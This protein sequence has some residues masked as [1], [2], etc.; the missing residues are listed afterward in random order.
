MKV[1]DYVA[2]KVGSKYLSKIYGVYY[3][4]SQIPFRSLPEKF[5]L[6]ANHGSGWNL[7]VRHKSRMSEG[8]IRARCGAWLGQVYSRYPEWWY[9][10]I[11]PA[12]LVEEFLED[13]AG[14]VPADYKFFVFRGEVGLIQVD[15]ARFTDHRRNLYGPDWTPLEASLLY[16]RGAEIPRPAVF[17]EMTRVAEK[18]G[19]DFDF[20][21][22]DLYALGHRVVF[23]EMTYL[24]ESGS[25]EFSSRELDE[26]M[27]RCLERAFARR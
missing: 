5:V 17:D 27:T 3:Q 7:L 15:T 2:S 18:L 20:V 24:P 21:R 13:A 1:R 14:E 10:E 26:Q 9:R 4:A 23:G 19:E 8:D 22:I 12:L 25:A 6:K 11:T 16:P